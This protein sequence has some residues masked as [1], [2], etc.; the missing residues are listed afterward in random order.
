M[1]ADEVLAQ[2]Q[3]MAVDLVILTG[4]EPMN[5]QRRLLEVLRGFAAEAIAVEVETNGTRAPLPEIQELVRRFVVSP[6]LAHSG[7]PEERR[8]QPAAL[9]A[10]QASGKAEYKFVVRSVSD[11]DA[12]AEIVQEYDL[13][14]VWIM[15]EGQ[16]ADTLSRTFTAIADAVVSRRWNLTTRLHVLAWGDLRG[17]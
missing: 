2:F 13:W 3:E 11:L 9:A 4:G 5:Q 7:D 17:V 14:P 12:V 10:F 6:K 16:S 1:S 8:I 15:P